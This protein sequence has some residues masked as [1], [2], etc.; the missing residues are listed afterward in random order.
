M[1][2]DTIL[3]DMG[4]VVCSFYQG[5]A[6]ANLSRHSKSGK[7]SKEVSDI[8][9]GSSAAKGHYNQGLTED[10][11]LGRQDSENFYLRVREAL[12]LDMSYAN[13][14]EAWSNMFSLN[15]DVCN[16]IKRAH[17]WGYNQG[18]LSSTNPIH[19]RAMD[20]LA[21]T[22]DLLG[23]EK[24]ICTYHKDAGFKKPS[25]ELFEAATRRLNVPKEEVIY[26]DDVKD[27]TDAA[28]KFGLGGAVH[29]DHSSKDY[30]HNCIVE[31]AKL[32][33]IER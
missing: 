7:T 9:F 3:W 27:Y 2:L 31:L 29:V 13:F 20:N 8:L 4:G 30:Q 32:G 10:Y 18:V 11:Y 6:N 28:L 22:E 21:G 26:V 19:W 23:R 15:E 14:V 1:A 24:I 33:I 25:F 5:I 12:D 16:F 17:E